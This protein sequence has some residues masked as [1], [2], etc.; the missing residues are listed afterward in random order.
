MPFLREKSGRWSPEKI[1]AFVGACIPALWLAWRTWNGDLNPAR[2]VNEAI[3]SIG[4]YTIWLIVLSLAIS[5]ARRLFNAPKLINMRR[6]LGVAAFCYAVLH[7]TLYIVQEKYD[8]LKVASEIVLRIY[9]TIGFVALIGLG[10]LASTSTDGMIKRLGGERWNR[11]H[12]LVYLIAILGIIHFMMQTKVDITES[13]MVGGFLI[14]LL[15]Y[16][17][18]HRYVGTVGP[19]SQIVLTI[20]ASALTALAEAAWYGAT[21]GVMWTRVLYANLDADVWALMF[22][23]AQ[24]VLIV[25]VAVTLASFAWSFRTQGA[26]ARKTSPRAASGAIQVQSAS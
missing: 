12:K 22:R 9:L 25:G 3:H 16:R 26:K 7:L 15:G 21:T 18:W 24:W 19:V 10:A 2:P 14:W 13:V 23:P 17:L 20:T 11:L 1:I 5:P 6:T 4:N 8:F